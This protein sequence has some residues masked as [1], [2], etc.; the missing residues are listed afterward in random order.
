[1]ARAKPKQRGAAGGGGDDVPARLIR[2]V[3]K[4]EDIVRRQ[5]DGSLPEDAFPW[6]RQPP[7]GGK[8]GGGGAD[9]DVDPRLV[10]SAVAMNAHGEAVNKYMA[11][12]LSKAE[13]G[14]AA[15]KEG[16][17]KGRFQSKFKGSEGGGGGGGGGAGGGVLGA[18]LDADE[19]AAAAVGAGR[20]GLARFAEPPNRPRQYVGGRLILFFVGGVTLPEMAA[21]DRLAKE[22]NR[23]IIV[24]GTSILTAPDLLEQ[25]T[26]TEP[27]MQDRDGDGDGGGGGGAGGGGGGGDGGMGA[28]VG[29]L[30]DG[31]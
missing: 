4:A 23:E 12:A 24:G 29:D 18:G 20:A 2:Y 8:G 15:G 6:A 26:L 11:S 13:A 16:G 5:L 10:S 3:T 28:G 30:L 22:T 9:G 19:S 17:K 25:L 31:F 14:G 21:L 1:V 27:E 7:K